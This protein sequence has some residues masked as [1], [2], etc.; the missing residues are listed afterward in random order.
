MTK[1]E[2][3]TLAESSPQAKQAAF[4]KLRD[5]LGIGLLIAV[6]LSFTLLV[7]IPFI[8]M[9]VMSFRTTGEILMNPYGLPEEI[10]FNNYVRLFTDPQIK[11]GQFFFN[12][13]FVTG[14]SLLLTLIL[15][16]LGGYGFGRSR[17]YFRS[18]GL[19]FTALLF[20]LMLP[21]QI[22]YL[23][24]FEM[25][26][27]YGLL[28]TRWALILVYVAAQLPISTYLMSTYFATLPQELEDAA[29]IDGCN[30]FGIFWRVMFPLARPAIA[31]V[32][33]INFLNF[34]NELLLAITLVTDPSK[35]TLPAAMMMF[36]G[37]HGS[38]YGLAAASLVSAMLPI[39]ILYLLLSEKFIEGLTAGAVKG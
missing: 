25:M 29:R 19:L 9:L 24:Q 35:R 20:G 38:N 4:R 15:S 2:R 26:S 12:S 21:Q 5:Y 14:F 30:D 23:P 39:F 28:N 31:T 10:N 7:I 18:R 27:R 36:V 33:L 34:W 22:L 16:T 6:L 32:V 37:E 11:F 3:S 1:V 13:V 17:Y 8:W